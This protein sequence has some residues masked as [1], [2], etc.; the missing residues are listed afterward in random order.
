M[1]PIELFLSASSYGVAG[2]SQ[3]RSKFGN[4][5]LRAL[6]RTGRDPVPIHPHAS[7]IEG[8]KAYPNLE[9]APAIES[10]VIITPPSVTE[11]VVRDALSHGVKYLWMQPGAESQES[12]R[13]AND[14]ELV[15]IAGGP[16]LLIAL[17]SEPD[18][19]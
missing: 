19:I 5:V 7:K 9:S 13:E 11:Q 15:V 6:M 14:G 8:L 12:I 1:T 3:D 16:C 10:L 4:K 18:L 17:A 2:A